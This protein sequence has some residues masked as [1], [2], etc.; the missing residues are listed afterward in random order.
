M[1]VTN[2]ELNAAYAAIANG[3]TYIKPKLY[4]KVIDHDGNVILDNT[5]PDSR[6]VIKETTAW[7]LTDAMMDV[8]TQGRSGRFHSE[9]FPECG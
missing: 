4:T 8:V 3:G 5:E 1:G 6:Q 7:L 9:S 2:E